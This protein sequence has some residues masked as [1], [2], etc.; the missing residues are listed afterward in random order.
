MLGNLYFVLTMADHGLV[1][2]ERAM[3]GR[4]VPRYLNAVG[5]WSGSGRKVPILV[6]TD[7]E[8]AKGAALM[9]TAARKRAVTVATLG[10]SDLKI[11]KS[12]RLFTP[13]DERALNG[14]I[15]SA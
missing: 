9:A 2:Q 1:A 6:W 11:G 8:A 7:Q 15:D 10:G 4:H 14:Y 12:I 3:H 13:E 5:R